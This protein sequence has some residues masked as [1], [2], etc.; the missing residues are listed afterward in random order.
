MI[1]KIITLSCLKKSGTK[2]RLAHIYIPE[3]RILEGKRHSG[4][5][6]KRISSSETQMKPIAVHKLTKTQ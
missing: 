5:L 4:A 3:K 1:W 6:T 2:H